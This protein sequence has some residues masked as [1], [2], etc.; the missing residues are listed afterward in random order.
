[1]V[2]SGTDELLI[3]PFSSNS[4]ARLMVGLRELE[5]TVDL[6]EDLLVVGPRRRSDDGTNVVN[7]FWRSRSCGAAE[8]T[9]LPAEI[10][11]FFDVCS[12]LTDGGPWAA[13]PIISKW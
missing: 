1:L 6:R 5:L 8:I 7:S 4:G 2:G 3:W 12:G 9:A 11:G 13:G 10:T